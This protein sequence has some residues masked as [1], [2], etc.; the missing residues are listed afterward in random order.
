MNRADDEMHAREHEL[1]RT[2]A[3]IDAHP[4]PPAE[5]DNASGKPRRAP[6]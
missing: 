1:A 6:F 5:P 4:A 2:D 3:D